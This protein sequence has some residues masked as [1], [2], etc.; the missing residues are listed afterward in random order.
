MS[1]MGFDY[2]TSLEEYR[3]LVLAV[4]TAYLWFWAAWQALLGGLKGFILSSLPVEEL[5][6]PISRTQIRSSSKGSAGILLLQYILLSVYYTLTFRIMEDRSP[7][8]LLVVWLD[9]SFE[10][11]LGGIWFAGNLRKQPNP[12]STALCVS[13]PRYSLHFTRTELRLQRPITTL[14]Y[15]SVDLRSV[16]L[17]EPPAPPSRRQRL[18]SLREPVISHQEVKRA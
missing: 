4:C 10:F 15:A 16:E 2:S 6:Y 9:S 13:L 17:L 11:H 14:P 3:L 1:H 12:N 8:F 18:I 7:V 5:S